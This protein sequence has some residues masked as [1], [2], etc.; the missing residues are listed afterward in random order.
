MK[1]I[2]IKSDFFK[3]Y[4]PEIRID[5]NNLVSEETCDCIRCD[6]DR[7][8]YEAYIDDLHD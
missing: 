4:K 3:D 6:W 5:P 8:Q 1:K 2:T 7:A